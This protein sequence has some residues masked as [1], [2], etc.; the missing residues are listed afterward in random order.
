MLKLHA[1]VQIGQ[2]DVARYE[3]LA[4][5]AKIHERVAVTGAFAASVIG[6]L[7]VAYGALRYLGRKKRP[8][9]SPAVATETTA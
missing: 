9:E 4:H 6:V 8:V 5:E 3:Q 7:A 1:L 2:S